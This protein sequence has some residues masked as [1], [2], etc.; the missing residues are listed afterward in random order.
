MTTTV[1]ALT[2]GACI[3]LYVKLR[4]VIGDTSE[5]NLREQLNAMYSAL[6]NL[7]IIS[8]D[9]SFTQSVDVAI[10]KAAGGAY[11]DLI[12]SG[13]A[14][15]QAIT[16][17]T[18]GLESKPVIIPVLKKVID[19][20][21]SITAANSYRLIAKYQDKIYTYPPVATDGII[22]VSGILHPDN[23]PAN[24]ITIPYS[25]MMAMHALIDYHLTNKVDRASLWGAYE[26]Q[27]K[28]LSGHTLL[29]IWEKKYGDN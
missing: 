26:T 14:V 18:A 6:L 21:P 7:H 4:G 15:V 23:S 3:D 25:H 17:T 20:L 8:W 13:I 19:A 2:P 12:P 22:T 10:A 5:V 24:T 16:N 27:V 29:D 1:N 9:W 11:F 28:L